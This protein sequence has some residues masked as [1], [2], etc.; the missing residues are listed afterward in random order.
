MRSTR[1]IDPSPMY[2]LCD[3][4][5]VLQESRADDNSAAGRRRAM[6][7]V[8]RMLRSRPGRVVL[9]LAGAAVAGLAVA[10]LG[11][12]LGNRRML[13]RG[14]SMRPLLHEGECVLV[15]RLAYRLGR[16][17][18]RGDVALVRG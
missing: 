13:V 6:L 14:V 7:M 4:G 18:R 16:R 5:S 8:V 15:D 3:P 2:R 12:L 9:A 1:L 11:V 10:V 17:P